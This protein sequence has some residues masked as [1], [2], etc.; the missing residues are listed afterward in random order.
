[1]NIMPLT[2]VPAFT[3]NGFTPSWTTVT[4]ETKKDFEKQYMQILYVEHHGNSLL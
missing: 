3:M 4:I 1:M 2:I